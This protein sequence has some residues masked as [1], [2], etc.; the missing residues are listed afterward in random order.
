MVPMTVSFFLKG[1]E[2]K[3]RGRFR[4][5]MY[6]LFI[7]LLYTLPIAALIIITRWLGGDAVTADIFN[8]SLRTGC[9]I[10]SSSSYS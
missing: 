5:G 6:G 10:S 1:S 4:A 9:R 3:A 8:C 2:N 7:I